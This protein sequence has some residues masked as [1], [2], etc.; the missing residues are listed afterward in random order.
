MKKAFYY[1]VII[2][3]APL[4]AIAQPTV[5]SISPT[6]NALSIDKNTNI[7]VTFSTNIDQST[8]NNSTIK[9]NGSISGPHKATFNYNASAQTLTITPASSFKV[10][11][12]VTTTL[13]HGIKSASGDSLK[14]GYSWSFS[15]KSD[16]SSSGKFLH[17]STPSVGIA[18]MSSTT[19][20]FNGD[21]YLDLAV[22]CINDT[23]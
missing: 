12:V 1:F 19:G 5:V 2:I 21:G 11:E 3:V 13:T 20:D 17:S 16:I 14:W 23:A 9:I 18:P 15:I 8:I 4:L 7:T 6:R 10:G 22:Q